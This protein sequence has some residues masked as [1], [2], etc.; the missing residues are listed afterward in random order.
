VIFIGYALG[1]ATLLVLAALVVAAWKVVS[2]PWGLLALLAVLGVRLFAVLARKEKA[3]IPKALDKPKKK[4]Q[5]H[6]VVVP[7]KRRKSWLT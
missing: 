5:A 2:S 7:L 4:E 6:A 1:A 3:P